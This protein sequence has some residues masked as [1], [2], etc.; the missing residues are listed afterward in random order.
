M[1]LLMEELECRKA[2]IYFEIKDFCKVNA[3]KYLG[4]AEVDSFSKSISS[5]LFGHF[6]NNSFW[7]KVTEP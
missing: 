2:K 5:K 7:S 3:N 4:I 6:G 1:F